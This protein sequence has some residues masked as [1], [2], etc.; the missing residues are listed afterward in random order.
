MKISK[1]DS[2]LISFGN[3][4]LSDDRK[5]FFKSFKSI[6][7]LSLNERLSHVYSSDLENWKSLISGDK[8]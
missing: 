8:K 7:G 6:K 1:K 3:Y 2:D 5:K 4:L